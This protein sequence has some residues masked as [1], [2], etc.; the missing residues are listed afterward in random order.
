MSEKLP[1]ELDQALRVIASKEEVVF[2]KPFEKL[3]IAGFIT[4]KIFG[5]LVVNSK[6]WQYLNEHPS[7]K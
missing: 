2:R 7:N 1:F 5:G 3:V 4:E 6:G